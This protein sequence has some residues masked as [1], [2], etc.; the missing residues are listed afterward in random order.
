MVLG[1]GFIDMEMYGKG[2]RKHGLKRG[3]SLSS[4]WS[5]TMVVFHQ[6]DFF[7]F[8]MVYCPKVTKCG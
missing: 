4:G 3:V 1:Q 7:I 8:I 2:V 6:V 5:L